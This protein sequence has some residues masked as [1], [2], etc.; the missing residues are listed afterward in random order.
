MSSLRREDPARRAAGAP[1]GRPPG[2]YLL[3]SSGT[4]LSLVA[5]ALVLLLGHR[6]DPSSRR[7]DTTT[8]M[9]TEEPCGGRNTSPHVLAASEVPVAGP[10]TSPPAAPALQ[11]VPRDPDAHRAP[12]LAT[13]GDA[14][15]LPHPLTPHPAE[16]SPRLSQGCLLC[17]SQHHPSSS[18][19]HELGTV[20]GSP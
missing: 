2:P 1:T 19:H 5:P 10:P 18:A 4:S 17:S 9:L 8:L 7:P 3:L 12:P 16:L 11:A 13:P 6:C 14:R 15:P 20:T